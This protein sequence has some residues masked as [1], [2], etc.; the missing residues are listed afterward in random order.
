[1]GEVTMTIK[2]VQ[3]L[4]ARHATLGTMSL[5]FVLFLAFLP[6]SESLQAKE[7]PPEISHD[8]LHRLHDTKVALAY[9]KPD[10]DFSVYNRLVILD[11][12]VAFKKNSQRDQNDGRKSLG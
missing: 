9:A 8:G 11:C 12:H 1:M 2:K 7:E 3:P 4:S 10:A 5:I 6:Y